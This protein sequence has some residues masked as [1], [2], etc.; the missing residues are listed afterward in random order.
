MKK[1]CVEIFESLSKIVWVDA[2]SGDEAM[3][4]VK[5]GYDIEKY[6][7]TADNYDGVDFFIVDS[8]GEDKDE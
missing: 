6:V 3:K 1:Y 8:I 2:E 5:D 4:K 7:L